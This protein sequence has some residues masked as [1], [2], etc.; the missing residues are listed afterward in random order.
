MPP[1]IELEEIRRNQILSAA[2]EAIAETGQAKVTM[3]GICEQASLSKGGVA[4]YFSSKRE[5]F[6]AAFETYFESIFKRS[7]EILTLH[8]DPVEQILSF[9]WLLD[10][11]S[12]EVAH[13]Y[14][15]LIDFMALA[16]HDE[17]YSRIYQRW[18][19]RWLDLVVG[20]LERGQ[21]KGCFLQCDP[22]SAAR[23]IS[24]VYQ[25]FALRWYLT[26]ELYPN[27]WA[28]ATLEETLK[29]LLVS[30]DYQ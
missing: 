14:P 6:T 9:T 1:I 25:G 30:F 15:V 23:T 12:P 16:A 29:A 5:L 27:Q 2:I 20:V 21:S 4:H 18:V 11:N 13:G 8:E 22:E 26:P 28:A 19:R 3:A 10:P 7:K 24:A 17:I